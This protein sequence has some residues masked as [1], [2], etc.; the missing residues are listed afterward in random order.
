MDVEEYADNANASPT[1]GVI[2]DGTLKE[3]R[4]LTAKTGSIDDADGFYNGV[5]IGA[6]NGMLMVHQ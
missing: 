5:R 1:G 4:T 6:F 3:D 2:I